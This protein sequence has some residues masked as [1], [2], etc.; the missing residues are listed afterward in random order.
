MNELVLQRLR[1]KLAKRDR[2]IEGMRRYIQRLERM[3]GPAMTDNLD[4]LSPNVQ[5]QLI[6][7]VQRAMANVRLIPVIGLRSDD[8]VVRVEVENVK[9]EKHEP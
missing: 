4:M 6:A 2:R 8:R 3:L 5:R 9:E 7:A 1:K